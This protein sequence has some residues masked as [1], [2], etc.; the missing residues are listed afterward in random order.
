MSN[1]KRQKEKVVLFGPL[2]V[3]PKGICFLGAGGL[4][5]TA[6]MCMELGYPKPTLEKKLKVKK[7]RER[8]R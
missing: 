4:S 3:E 2:N 5:V 1:G 7:K 6:V 8:R